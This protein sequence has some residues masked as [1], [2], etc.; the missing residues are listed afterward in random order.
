MLDL[1]T[2][3]WVDGVVSPIPDLVGIEAADFATPHMGRWGARATVLHLS[4]A[5]I[6]ALGRQR[7]SNF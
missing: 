4:P 5:T 7:S 6:G 3:K 1:L 2:F